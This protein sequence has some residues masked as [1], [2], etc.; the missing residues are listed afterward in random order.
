MCLARLWFRHYDIPNEGT[1]NVLAHTYQYI[2]GFNFLQ[3]Q[4]VSVKP[5]NTNK[6]QITTQAHENISVI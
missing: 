5:N 3:R 4:L 2:L 1:N 6:G